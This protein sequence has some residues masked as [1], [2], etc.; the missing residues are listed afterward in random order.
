MVFVTDITPYD[1]GYNDPIEM[2]ITAKIRD[3]S[4]Q[5]HVIFVQI[6]PV[7]A[8]VPTFAACSCVTSVSKCS[9]GV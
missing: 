6:T 3:K 1:H 4:T 8:S 7:R 2:T 5:K 9:C